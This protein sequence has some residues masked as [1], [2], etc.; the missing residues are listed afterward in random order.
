[1][2]RRMALVRTDLS[3]EFS[4]SIIKVT[5]ISELGTTLAVNSNRRTLRSNTKYKI[6]S[7]FL[8]SVR[9]LLVT[10]NIVPS[11]PILVA[12][13]MEAL[14]SSETSVLARATWCNIPKDAILLNLF[15][16]DKMKHQLLL[17]VDKAYSG[18]EVVLLN[19]S[20]SYED[21]QGLGKCY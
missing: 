9:R 4:T 14:S 17:L 20:V 16:A 13:M 12:L 5:R 1:M 8:R 2:L 18:A 7:V 11:S 19:V 6:Q 10:A 21:T 15:S 3:E